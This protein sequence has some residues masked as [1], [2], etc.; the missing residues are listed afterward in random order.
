MGDIV[1]IS[2]ATGLV[3]KAIAEKLKEQNISIG[4]L[5][6]NAEKAKNEIPFADDIIETN[7]ED[8]DISEKI[9]NAKGV[10]NLAGANINGKRWTEEY[11]Q[12]IYNSRIKVTRYLAEQINA[13]ES[14]PEVFVSVSGINY[15]GNKQDEKLT[16]ESTSGS[17]FLA[18]VTKDWEKEANKAIGVRKVI[19]R[20]GVVLDRKDGAFPQMMTP[21]KF[22][23][24]GKLGTGRQW[25]SWIHLEDVAALFCEAVLNESWEGVY[26][27][28]SPDPVRNKTFIKKLASRLNRPAIFAVPEFA[29]KAV[30]GE[31][32]E[33]IT[34]SLRVIPEKLLQSGYEFKYN[35][36]DEAFDEL[37]N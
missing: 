9:G 15:Y 7:Y 3:G 25:F 36:I 17:D 21:V 26:N 33:L 32:A 37:V 35:N 4:V 12:I 24:G 10:V 1:Y 13:A 29:L 34:A 16:E 19:P 22:F 5:T 6:R 14:K 30:I 23:V 11:K 2:G 8:I 31:A 28:A 18:N 20:L 27:F